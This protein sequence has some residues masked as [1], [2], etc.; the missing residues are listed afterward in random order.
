[1]LQ[2]DTP[3]SSSKNFWMFC[4]SE[5]LHK[6]GFASKADSNYF[7]E[8]PSLIVD[9]HTYEEW[10][11]LTES[12]PK[13]FEVPENLFNNKVD[14]PKHNFK[15]GMKLEAVSPSDRTK[16]CPATV[17]KVF[18]ETYFLVHIDVYEKDAENFDENK[19]YNPNERNTWLCTAEHPYIFPAGWSKNNNIR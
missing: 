6:H 12:G 16:L 8:P 15:P 3:G 1:M 14:H 18:D 7:L 9:T 10:K 19:V 2:Y 11:E 17:I 13:N 4:T 5:H